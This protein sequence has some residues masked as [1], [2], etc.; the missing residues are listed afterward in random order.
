LSSNPP[1]GFPS[2]V[3]LP[4]SLALRFPLHHPNTFPTNSPLFPTSRTL[5]MNY[6]HHTDNPFDQLRVTLCPFQ[7]VLG[8]GNP[9]SR[10]FLFAKRTHFQTPQFPTQPLVPAPVAPI[11]DRRQSECN[12]P[13]F[14]S[15]PGGD[16]YFFAFTSFFFS[17]A[18]ISF[19][20]SAMGSFL[21]NGKRTVAL[22]VS[23]VCSS[24]SC[25]STT[26]V[27]I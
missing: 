25:S 24:F 11:A 17:R 3:L 7:K 4:H 26:G 2:V 21:S 13:N 15:L 27:G 9:R 16:F 12:G 22:L 20:M 1:S 5:L 8:G 10:I 19:F 6:A 23:Y 14:R 18:F